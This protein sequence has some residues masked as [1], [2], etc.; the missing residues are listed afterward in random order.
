[1]AFRIA[2]PV[3]VGAIGGAVIG[4]SAIWTLVAYTASP[5]F[6]FGV[7]LSYGLITAI[8]SGGLIIALCVA[9][10]FL[11]MVLRQLSERPLP[12]LQAGSWPVSCGYAVG[13]AL[14]VE[15]QPRVHFARDVE[16][17]LGIRTGSGFPSRRAR[18]ASLAEWPSGDG[19]YMLFEL[20]AA[21]T[22]HGSS[23]RCC[24]PAARSPLTSRRSVGEVRTVRPPK[25]ADDSRARRETCARSPRRAACT[26]RQS[27]AG[28]VVGA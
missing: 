10:N 17:A 6:S 7:W 2:S 22:V 11:T 26:S 4:G 1:M 20:A 23:A 5:S 19:A 3:K 13:L 18:A 15:M 25:H 14:A 21:A 28:A 9:W 24:A 12:F 27:F 16:P 8:L